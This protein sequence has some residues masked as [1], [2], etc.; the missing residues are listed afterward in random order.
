MRPLSLTMQAFGSYGKKTRIDFT[1][2]NQNL[3]LIA[4]DTGAG[5][6]TIF[7][8]IVFALYGEAS[9]GSN[10]KD[11]AEL[12]SQ[13]E[14]YGVEPL[15]ELV[16]SEMAGGE[17]QVYT[18]RRVPRHIR[19][20]KKGKGMKE[21]KEKISLLLPDGSEYSQNQKETDSR[22][23]EIVGLTK[24]QFM[25]VG[26]IAQG[27]FMEL[28]RAKSDDKKVI[29]RKLFHTGFFQQVVEELARRRKEKEAGIEQLQAACRKDVGRTEL[30][31]G[32]EAELAALRKRILSAGKFSIA[33]LEAFLTGL[34][35]L[36]E[37][38]EKERAAAAEHQEKLSELRDAKRDAYAGAV[39]VAKSFEQLRN[40][41]ADLAACALEESTME[42]AGRLMG[43]ILSAYEIQSVHER[44]R[45]A[46]ERAKNLEE[47]LHV[48][49]SLLPKLSEEAEAAGLA[50]LQAKEVYERE[51][52][53]FAKV[54]ERVRRALDVL[55]KLRGAEADVR[56][57]RAGL[58]RAEAAVKAAKD[59]QEEFEKEEEKNRQQAERL[60]GTEALLVLW[61]GKNGEADGIG[62]DIQAAKAAQVG[63]RS[64]MRKAKMAQEAYAGARKAAEEKAREYLRKQNEFLDAQAGF[65]AQEKLRPGEPCPVCGSC[66]HPSP[67]RLSD[68]HRELTRE[69]LDSLREERDRLQG[70]QE[71]KS[72]KAGSEAALLE[73]RKS[74]FRE[75]GEKLR[76]RMGKSLSDLPAEMTLKQAEERLENW[77]GE[78]RREGEELQRKEKEW[79]AAQMFLKHAEERKK[80]CREAAEKASDREKEAK[81]ALAAAEATQKQLQAQRDYP[82]EEE[83]E[84]VRETSMATKSKAEQACKRAA[85][86]ARETGG[87]REQAEAL[88]RRYEKELP[89]CRAEMEQRKAAYDRAMK[90]KDLA[91]SEWQE[92]CSKHRKPEAE[93]IRERLERHRQRKHSAEGA[94]EAARKAIG[95]QP[96]PDLEK[97][98][99]EKEAAEKSHQEAQAVLERR[100]ILCRANGE[101]YG[102]LVSQMEERGRMAREYSRLDSLYSRLSG[103]VTGARMDIETFVQ[104]YYLRQILQAANVRFRKMSAGQFEL[105]MVGEEQA[106][107]GKNRGL[108]L[109]V[110]SAV[111]GK[112]REVRTLSGGESFMA[113]LS[114]ALGMADQIQESSAA[115]HLDV[116]FIDEGF[117]SLDDHS[118]GQAV[119]VLQQVANGSRLIGI[120]S[121]VAELKQEIEDQL[122]VSKDEEGSHVKWQIS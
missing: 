116:M 8:A 113:A 112:E 30:P 50:E 76:E 40:A 1:Q 11:G 33:D 73:E 63:I 107:A 84:S 14:D 20:L 82:T 37:E 12:Q 83:A 58:A 21:E 79:K 118:R 18:V 36:C 78:L 17:E 95:N 101:A 2:P 13:F 88:V 47:R 62:K 71:Q 45:D 42:E 86:A 61:Q 115:I 91:E 109:M 119:K 29:F 120:I 56:N 28:L 59:A 110:Y 85:R 96:V 34:G 35:R 87:A 7:D 94:R 60:G 105:R 64:Q 52:E 9:S 16:F 23:E 66:E 68:E 22:I 100:K 108:D 80:A 48:Q 53:A 103:K 41:E 5:K 57:R 46:A 74:A 27:E 43:Q 89:E 6:T 106:G 49:K 25:Q 31:E 15:V 77:Q 104:R 92:L 72:G 54:E 97:L 19:P 65:L 44:Y 69:M 102:A 67:C 10:R 4:G 122:L 3:F 32:Q 90:E 98:A 81:S 70:E 51:A 121:H 24:G 39:Q 26:M 117:G 38:M 111:T 114:L 99:E 55:D 93:E 75:M